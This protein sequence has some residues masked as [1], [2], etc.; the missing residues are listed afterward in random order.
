MHVFLVYR[1]EWSGDDEFHA[2]G[3]AATAQELKARQNCVSPALN[4]TG[5][6]VGPK[7]RL[8]EA[9]SGTSA[10][11]NAVPH[12]QTKRVLLLS[13]PSG[14]SLLDDMVF[15]DLQPRHRNAHIYTHVSAL[16]V[17]SVFSYA[18][19]ATCF[20]RKKRL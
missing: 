5:H 12:Q 10:K 18:P 3:G 7:D 16:T 20:N 19:A 14:F 6:I 13:F 17:E 11:S 2:A 8:V 9:Q 4:V 1:A 15:W